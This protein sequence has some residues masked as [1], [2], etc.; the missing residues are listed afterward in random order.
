MNTTAWAID[1]PKLHELYR[2][3]A[4]D[5][6]DNYFD[7]FDMVLSHPHWRSIYET[8]ERQLSQLDQTAWQEFKERTLPCVTSRDQKRDWQ[9]LFD[10][11]DEVRGY[12][13]LKSVGCEEVHFIPRSKRKHIK[14]PDLC[15][16]HGSF[17]MLMEV[18]TIN[19]SNDEIK[20]RSGNS[21]IGKDGKRHVQDREIGQCWSDSRE[22]L[23]KKIWS[24]Y[25]N[26]R[27][28]L[29]T[30]NCRDTQ[31]RIVYFMIH[32]D[33]ALSLD[34]HSFDKFIA[35]IGLLGDQRIEVVWDYGCIY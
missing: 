31:R 19:M 16:Q 11:F 34:A 14:T 20:Y 32:F 9:A 15:G 13:W 33:L 23:K 35:D 8:L 26:A 25:D 5:K 10:A 22:K 27:N 3:S 21:E 30:H 2:D 6:V 24:T 4:R 28:Q 7:D 29:L 1:L 18:K 12:L 17:K